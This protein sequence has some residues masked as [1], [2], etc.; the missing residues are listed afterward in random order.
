MKVDEDSIITGSSD[1]VLRLLSIQPHA[2]VGILGQHAEFGCETIALSHDKRMLAS[3]SYGPA[4]RLWDT[5]CLDESEDP[6]DAEAA[7]TE[8]A[9]VNDPSLWRDKHFS[10]CIEVG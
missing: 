8:S 4:V 3:T 9:K 5:S 2:L 7:K 10:I 1:G 6:E